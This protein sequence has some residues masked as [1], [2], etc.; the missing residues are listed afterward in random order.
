[1]TRLGKLVGNEQIGQTSRGWP[2]W[3]N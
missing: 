1:M 3:A 2:V